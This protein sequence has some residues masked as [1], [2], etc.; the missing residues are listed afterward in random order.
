MKINVNYQSGE[1]RDIRGGVDYML[2]VVDDVELYAEAAITEETDEAE[3]AR[4]TFL[5]SEILRQAEEAGIDADRLAF[6]WDGQ[7]DVIDA[8]AKQDAESI[9]ERAGG[10]DAAVELMDDDIREEL[11]SE[12]APCDEVTF[13]TAY[14]LRHAQKYGERFQI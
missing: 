1:G 9:C 12:L 5:R 3:N 7:E 11:H 14:I 6:W 4:Y 10:F 8:F 2:A 13:L